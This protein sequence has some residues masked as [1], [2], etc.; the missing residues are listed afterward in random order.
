MFDTKDFGAAIFFL[1]D[2]RS[3]FL[4]LSLSISPSP[5]LTLSLSFPHFLI[6]GFLDH[7]LG[8]GG[9]GVS[10]L[11]SVFFFFFKLMFF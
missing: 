11:L 9:G 7:V 8:V 10:V 5:S 4:P 2:Q 1:P 6:L 3:P